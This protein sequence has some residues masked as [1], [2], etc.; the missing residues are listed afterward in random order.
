MTLSMRTELLEMPFRDPF[1]IARTEDPE[2]ARTII[3]ELELDGLSGVGECYPVPYYGETPA[4]VMAVLPTLLDAL[5]ALGPLPGDRQE[6]ADWLE[7]SAA[8]M[9]DALGHH[10]GAKAGLDIALHDIAG[11]A[12][13]LPLWE[14][15]GTSDQLPPTDYSLGLDE[16]A[17][18]A[19]RARRV[20]GFPAL[21]IKVGGPAD[22]ETL[23]AVR[24]V[25]TG[26]TA[27]RRQHR[28]AARAGGCPAP[29]PR[30]AGRGAHRATLPGAPAGAA[31][32]APRAEQPAHPGR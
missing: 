1:R 18:V 11:K 20:T 16:P 32:L 21:K 28:L 7:R 23:E 14:L 19:E 17:R 27:G 15:L 8:L 13:G 5:D 25:Y 9:G 6:A 31:A 29:G 4:T 3:V 10:G 12:L 22:V 30:A 24:E 26:P 2:S